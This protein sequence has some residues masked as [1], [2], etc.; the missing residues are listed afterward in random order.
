MESLD[1]SDQSFLSAKGWM[2]LRYLT[3]WQFNTLSTFS[4][5]RRVW[6]RLGEDAG[7]S[8]GA[9]QM[10]SINI[11]P[12]AIGLE[13]QDVPTTPVYRLFGDQSGNHFLK[14]CI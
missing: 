4:G 5:W 13:R 1:H 8:S 11:A 2:G 14:S 9:E 6:R 12:N 10:K 7:R 3:F